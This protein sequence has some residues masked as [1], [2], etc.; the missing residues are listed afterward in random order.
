MQAS[1]Q[2]NNFIKQPYIYRINFILNSLNSIYYNGS[3]VLD[4]LIPCVQL[5]YF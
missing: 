1:D 5:Y 4:F 3:A 2:C